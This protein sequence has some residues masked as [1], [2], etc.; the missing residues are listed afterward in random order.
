MCTKMCTS[1]FYITYVCICV[2]LISVSTFNL[3]DKL[4]LI[5]KGEVNS[6]F[7]FSV[8]QHKEFGENENKSWQVI[9]FGNTG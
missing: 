5:K 1:Y 8:A 7:G 9:L 4:P 3:D 6:Y 2:L